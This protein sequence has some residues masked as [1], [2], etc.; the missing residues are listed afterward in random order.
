MKTWVKEDQAQVW[1]RSQRQAIASGSQASQ[2]ASDRKKRRN[3][4]RNKR[5]QVGATRRSRIIIASCMLDAC[6]IMM[7]R[8]LL[9]SD[10]MR[11]HAS[12]GDDRFSLLL[13]GLVVVGPSPA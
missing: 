5:S 7:H 8:W 13:F 11:S 9:L 12:G 6:I 3:K 1:N 10:S 2:V 4:R